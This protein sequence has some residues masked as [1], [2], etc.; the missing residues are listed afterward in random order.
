MEPVTITE[1]SSESKTIKQSFPSTNKLVIKGD[2]MKD[3]DFIK[4]L[5][6]GT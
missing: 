3:K 4:Y 1:D 5:T 2:I 6:L